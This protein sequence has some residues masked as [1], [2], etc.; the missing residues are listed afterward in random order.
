MKT[1][2]KVALI[3]CTFFAAK[4]GPWAATNPAPLYQVSV[5]QTPTKAINYR[6]L[7]GSARIDFK[8][9]VLLPLGTGGAV[10]KNKSG[11]MH[12]KAEF[13]QLTPPM[14]FGPEYLTYV[15]WAITPDGKASNLGELDVR[16][17]E[18]RLKVS[19]PLQALSLIV[20]AEPY[21]AVSQPSN[22]VVFENAIP[23]EN[24]EKIDWIDARYELL[25]RG[26]YTRNIATTDFPPTV[27]D[28]KTPFAVYQARNAVRIAK[29]A[30]AET[31]A[32]EGFHNAERLLALSETKAGGKKGRSL[33]ARQAVQSA[34]DSRA[35]ALKRSAEETTATNQQLSQDA[36]RQAQ[37]VTA[38]AQAE[39]KMAR[40][41][42]NL[43]KGQ[44]DL[45]ND[46]VLLAEG[47]KTDLRSQL[48]SQLN[49][50]LQ[51]QD[52]ARG[53]IVNMSDA[54]FPTGSYT[55]GAPA[56]E[57][58]AK[59]AGIVSSHPGLNLTV[60]GHTDSV[61]SDDTNQRLSESRSRAARDYLV[62]Q[63]VPSTSVTSEGFGE[64]RPV[65]TNDSVD[66]RQKNRRVE[67]I[68]SGESIGTFSQAK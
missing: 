20:T 21:F 52:S 36:L 44:M 23:V 47:E 9:T 62:V 35:L 51:T 45:A 30:G 11:V 46:R 22:V 64:S 43:S 57:K 61:G 68:V 24:D 58:L 7:K 12:I 48:R 49:A 2:F 66:G 34:E 32:T 53:L 54:L 16:S 50:V 28:K 25:P 4:E 3:V 5:V 63:G 18:S 17:G 29:A 19:T 42:A 41:E 14:Q 1:P 27:M 6:D 59:I 65:T 37:G 8:G 60:E 40:A 33:T 39:T 10:V 13:N 55:L 26:E 15:L 38:M 67:I 56:R 31:H